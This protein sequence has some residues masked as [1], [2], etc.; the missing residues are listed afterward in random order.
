MPAFSAILFHPKYLM[1]TLA[2][3]LFLFS[4][5]K[6]TNISRKCL[7]SYNVTSLFTIIP[8]EETIDIAI[9]L[10]FDHNLNLNITKKELYSH[11]IFNSKFHNEIDRVAMGSPL[12][13]VLA[14][15]FMGFYKSKWL[16]E[17]NLNKHNFYLRY[18]DNSIISSLVTKLKTH[19]TLIT[20]SYNISATCHTIIKIIFRNS[21]KSFVKKMLT[22]SYFLVNLKLKIIFP[23]KTEFLMISNL[24]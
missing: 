12:I 15:I 11:L 6:N 13:P 24:S 14:N 20:L 3:T 7:V 22:L 8:P 17:Y 10:I 9:N 21:A 4:Q 18:V 16:N 1:I 5:I 2:K 23:I 19:L